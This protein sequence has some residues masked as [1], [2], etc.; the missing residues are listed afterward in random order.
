[1][2]R[3]LP[4][5][6]LATVAAVAAA[7][8]AT[9]MKASAESKTM[10]NETLPSFAGAV[11]WLNTKP[12]TPAELRGKVIL[13]EFWTYTCV[14]WLRTLP[15]VRAWAEK[16][17]D[18]GLVVIGVHTPEFGFEK[19]PDNIRLAMKA[20]RIEYPVAVDSN[21]AIWNA[22]GNQYWPAMYFIDAHG[23]IRHHHFGEGAYAESE[24]TIQQ[25]LVEAGKKDVASSLVSVDPQ[26]LEVAADSSDEMSAE[27]YLGSDR[28][29]NFS[30]SAFSRLA[31]NQW[32]LSGAWTI[33]RESVVLNEPGGRIAYRFHA[34]DVNLI[35]GP[36]T[37][38]NAI[39]FRVLVDGKPPGAARGGDVDSNGN[40]VVS[41]Q[42]TYQLIRQPKPI[43]DR[44]F[45]IDFT[46][47]GVEA[48]DFTF[49]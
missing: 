11:E 46:N 37:R 23:Q 22:F 30:S 40:G 15:Y 3:L 28:T 29:E 43:V 1:V 35:M 47:P 48:F 36:V 9:P 6:L 17:R 38:G 32:A 49:G 44:L 42:R 5:V 41:E 20:M 26:G 18:K 31:L 34:R 12:L 27:T 39:K 16:Y 2:R 7:P 25:L 21:Y 10:T 33:G 24:R 8:V 19:N 4:F 14:N 45:E 13:V